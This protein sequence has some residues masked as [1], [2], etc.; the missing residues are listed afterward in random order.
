MMSS[1][2][3]SFVEKE[4]GD[5]KSSLSM[6]SVTHSEALDLFTRGMKRDSM[7]VATESS[8]FLTLKESITELWSYKATCL[9]GCFAASREDASS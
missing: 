5:L 8:L 7:P 2:N 1:L 4:A 6:T 3:T 9:Q